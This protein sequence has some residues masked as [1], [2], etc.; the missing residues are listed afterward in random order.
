MSIKFF[1]PQS[2][3]IRNFDKLLELNNYMDGASDNL[4]LFTII[5]LDRTVSKA[6]PKINLLG[7]TDCGTYVKSTVANQ[8][9]FTLTFHNSIWNQLI[10]CNTMFVQQ[11]DFDRKFISI[12]S[13]HRSSLIFIYAYFHQ[14]K[15]NCYQSKM[16]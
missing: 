1:S 13:T 5:H 2:L 4:S 16:I 12:E 14:H 15:W 10:Q 7:G 9:F 6:M 11:V 8:I 3:S